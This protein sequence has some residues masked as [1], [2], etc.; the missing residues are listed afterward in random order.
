VERPLHRRRR[1][2]A[3]QAVVDGIYQHGDAEHVRRQDE[4]LALVVAHLAGAGQPVDGGEPFRLR[5]LDLADEGVEVLDKRRH[6]LPEPRV[7]DVLPALQRNLSEVLFGHVCHRSLPF[8][9]MYN[10]PD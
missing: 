9:R 7:R 6:H 1:R 8:I 10:Q 3:R 2:A 5:R 4:F